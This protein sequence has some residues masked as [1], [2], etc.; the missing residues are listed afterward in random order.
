LSQGSSGILQSIGW[1][2]KKLLTAENTE[3]PRRDHRENQMTNIL[4]EAL[5]LFS[6]YSGFSQ[7]SLR[8][9]AFDFPKIETA[10][11]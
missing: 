8:L 6:A 3:K 4:I 1:K 2:T 7:R 9:K 11:F 5:L 10:C